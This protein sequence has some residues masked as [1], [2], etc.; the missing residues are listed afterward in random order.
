MRRRLAGRHA[1]DEGAW[2]VAPEGLD[3]DITRHDVDIAF[4]PAAQLDAGGALRRHP[5]HGAGVV[6]PEPHGFTAM[7]E[8]ARQAPAHAE[9]AMVVDHLAED[10][11]TQGA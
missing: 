6:H 4:G 3:D 2:Q 10:L 7:G 11:P 9:V 8:V 1:G 5:G